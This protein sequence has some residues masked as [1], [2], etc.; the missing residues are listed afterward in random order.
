MEDGIGTLVGGM[1]AFSAPAWLL[2]KYE[3]RFGR[4]HWVKKYEE[5]VAII[6]Y[7][8]GS[9]LAFFLSKQ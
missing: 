5:S 4:P 1:I 6:L 7:F 2:D 3:E 8:L 9:F